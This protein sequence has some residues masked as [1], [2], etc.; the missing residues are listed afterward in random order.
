MLNSSAYPLFYSVFESLFYRI[1]DF[2][3][4]FRNPRPALPDGVFLPCADK[5]A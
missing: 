2:V 3:M 1:P 5:A 4:P